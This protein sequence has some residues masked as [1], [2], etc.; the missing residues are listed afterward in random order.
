[1]PDLNVLTIC[2]SLRRASFNARLLTVAEAELRSL[3]ASV[4]RYDGLRELPR[5][6]E[7]LD[8]EATAPHDVTAFRARLAAAHIVLI[9]T[10]VYNGS[11]P[12]GIRDVV[13]WVSRPMGNDRVK[14]KF[15]GFITAS[16][17]PNGGTPGSDYLSKVFG[18][19]GATIVEP[20]TAV[21][22]VSTQFDDAG[23]VNDDTRAALVATARAL[24]AAAAA[25][26][27]TV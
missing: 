13:D 26:G 21:G 27:S 16:P 18:F 1:M 2:G 10:P 5:Y 4:D 7:D 20:F 25:G 15:V 8:T 6:D 17:G 14:G 22:A 12:S 24:V 9:A 11:M 19:F 23:E 3:G